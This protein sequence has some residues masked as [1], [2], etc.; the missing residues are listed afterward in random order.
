M[1]DPV[2]STNPV[3]RVLD[4]AT[5][6]VRGEPIN[7]G[8]VPANAMFYRYLYNQADSNQ[9]YYPNARFRFF[10]GKGHLAVLQV[11]T[12][13]YG[14]DLSSVKLLWRHALLEITQPTP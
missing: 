14:I 9:A 4:M 2:N 5:N 12:V 11:G 6:K 10:Q 3:L 1:L 8:N 7:L 13:A